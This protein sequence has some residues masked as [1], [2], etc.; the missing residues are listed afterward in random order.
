MWNLIC[1]IIIHPLMWG[2]LCTTYSMPFKSFLK[3]L[4][5][6]CIMIL[7]IIFPPLPSLHPYPHLLKMAVTCTCTEREGWG[8]REWESEGERGRRIYLMRLPPIPS[9]TVQCTLKWRCVNLEGVVL[10]GYDLLGSKN[11]LVGGVCLCKSSGL[12][13]FWRSV[14]VDLI[15]QCIG[16]LI[17]IGLKAV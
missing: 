15:H 5:E 8:V 12:A 14:G 7:N 2:L 17:E 9:P 6:T 16:C 1:S 4:S 11:H 3:S 13:L 10:C